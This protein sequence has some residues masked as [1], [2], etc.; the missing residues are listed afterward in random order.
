MFFRKSDIHR[1]SEISWQKREGNKEIKALKE[2][3][4]QKL[5]TIFNKLWNSS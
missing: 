2:I 4:G 3:V 5:L 1:S